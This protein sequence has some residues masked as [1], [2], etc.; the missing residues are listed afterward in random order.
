VTNRRAATTS[1]DERHGS[2]LNHKC[3]WGGAKTKRNRGTDI[4]SAKVSDQ[5]QLSHWEVG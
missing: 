2:F 4:S 3:H 1:K 5:G